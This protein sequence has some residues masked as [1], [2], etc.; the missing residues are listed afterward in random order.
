M[1]TGYYICEPVPV[2]EFF[3]GRLDKYGVQDANAPSAGADNRCITDGQN[4]YLWVY[5][6]PVRSFARYRPSGR[7]GFMLQTIANEFEVEIFPEDDYDEPLYVPSRKP[8]EEEIAVMR[9]AW[10]SE[11]A[12]LDRE[13]EEFRAKLREERTAAS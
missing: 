2:A 12:E 5:G 9:A 11:C 10:R 13:I 1:S 4:N 7:P 3:G 8:T 6:D